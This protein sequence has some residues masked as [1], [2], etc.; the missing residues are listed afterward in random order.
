MGAGGHDGALISPF[1]ASY[2]LVDVARLMR[3]LFDV[4]MRPVG[5]TGS[6]RRVISYLA[7]EDGQTQASLARKLDVSRVAIGEAVDRLERTGHVERRSDEVDRRKW[8]VHLTAR[9]RSLLPE[10]YAAG[11]AAQAE[12]F[13]DL[14]DEDLARLRE[15]LDRLRRRLLDL[16][17]ETMGHED[18]E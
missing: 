13:R 2:L 10:M 6:T 9:A 11:E 15:I 8:R 3:E 17:D 16:K 18:A 4:R 5:L 1:D 14:S 12:W 7:R